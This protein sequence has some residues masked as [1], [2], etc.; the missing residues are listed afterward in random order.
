MYFCNCRCKRIVNLDLYDFEK[1]I[2]MIEMIE[3]FF[4]YEIVI[5]VLYNSVDY[6]YF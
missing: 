4:V 5:N 6:F 3:D 1:F 2:C